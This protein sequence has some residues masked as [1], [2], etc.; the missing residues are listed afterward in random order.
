MVGVE[1]GGLEPEAAFGVG[2]AEDGVAAVE[3]GA[4]EGGDGVVVGAGGAEEDG[5]DGGAVVEVEGGGFGDEVGEVVGGG[6]GAV[7]E[8]GEAWCGR[9]RCRVT[10]DLEGVGAA[11]GAQGAAEEVGQAGFG[12]VVGVEVVGACGAR[13]VRSAASRTARRPAA[14]GCQPS[15]VQVE[16]DGVGAVEAG[17][18]GAV[19]GR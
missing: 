18:E 15:L 4:A 7:D 6:E 17:E 9:G 10:A 19:G 16:G 14:T 5:G 8:V 1:E 2:A 12:V 11:G 3:E 13:A